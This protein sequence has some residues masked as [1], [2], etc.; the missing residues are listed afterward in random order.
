MGKRRDFDIAFVGLKPG[1]HEFTY[2][3]GDEFFAEFETT[4]IQHCDAVVKVTLEKNTSF[5]I[6]KFE[7]DGSVS[8]SCDRCG[9]PLALMLWDEFQ[10]V[11]K[12]VESPDEMNENEDDP[13]IYYISRNESHLHLAGWIYEFV[14][15]SIPTQRMCPEDE[16]GNSQCNKEVLEMLQKMK[17]RVEKNNPLE[18]G[19]QKFKNNN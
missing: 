9:N 18:E 15:L 7:I 5:M 14:L 1:I 11:I 10:L 6:L 2:E 19:L 16:N 12:Q 4:E 13:D 17:E 8:V 3:V